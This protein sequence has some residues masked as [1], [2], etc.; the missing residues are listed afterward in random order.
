MFG[1][2]GGLGDLAGN[3]Y[4]TSSG[5]LGYNG[6]SVS[7]NY[8]TALPDPS[9]LQDP[10]ATIIFKSLLKKDSITKEKSLNE[11]LSYLDDQSTPVDDIFTVSWIQLYPKLAMDNSRNARV[12]A[13]QVQ[14]KL[15]SRLGGKAFSRYLKSSIPVWLSGVFDSDNVVSR[16]SYKSLVESFQDK[17]KVDV[18]LWVLFYEP[19]VNYIRTALTMETNESLSDPRYTKEDDSIAKYDRVVNGALTMLAKLIGL[20]N[21]G[22]LSENEKTIG[23]IDW[24]TLEQ[25]VS[26]DSVWDGHLE[27]C[28]ATKTLNL[29][30]FK[31]LLILIKAIFGGNVEGGS[32][33]L[34]HVEPKSL[35]KLISK[36]FLKHVK[37]KSSTTS[38]SV[39]ASIILQFWDTLVIL[40]R[41]SSQ[42]NSKVKKNF[43]DFSDKARSRLLGYLKLG[44][45]QSNPAYYSIIGQFFLELSKATKTE[46][47]DFKSNK[48]AK[49]ILVDILASDFSTLRGNDWKSKCL[50]CL[51]KVHACFK[52]VGNSLE[53]SQIISYQVLDSINGNKEVLTL[54]GNSFPDLEQVWAPF[55]EALVAYSLQDREENQ[56]F[57][58]GQYTFK[59][60]DMNVLATMYMKL[61]TTSKDQD[62]LQSLVGDIFE[63]ILDPELLRPSLAFYIIA[64][65]FKSYHNPD[66]NA[67]ATTQQYNLLDFMDNLPAY[68]EEDFVGPP[69]E[70]MSVI[71]H[72]FGGSDDKETTERLGE[73]VNDVFIKL[74]MVSPSKVPSFLVTLSEVKF[75]LSEHPEMFAYVVELS[76]RTEQLSADEAKVVFS[77]TQDDAIFQNLLENSTKSD[78]DGLVFIGSLLNDNKGQQLESTDLDSLLAICW[79]NI[80]SSK[81]ARSFVESGF[82][83]DEVLQKSLFEHIGNPT[84][85][86]FVELQKYFDIS[87]PEYFPTQQLTD[88]VEL[89]IESD[90]LQTPASQLSIANTVEQ[91]IVLGTT[92]S[93]AFNL[94]KSLVSVGTFL[95]GLK[96]VA[97]NEPLLFATG[98]LSE[99][100]ADVIFLGKSEDNHIVSLQEKLHNIFI[101]SVTAGLSLAD[102]VSV[103]DGGESKHTIS[104]II[105]S[106]STYA[107]RLLKLIVSSILDGVSL[108]NFDSQFTINLSK[109]ATK[110][111]LQFGSILLACS[112]FLATSSKF[113][114]IR[115]FVAAEILGVRGESKILSDGLKWLTLSINFLFN[116]DNYEFIPPHRLMMVLNTISSWLESDIAYDEEF[117][118]MRCQISRFLVGLMEYDDTPS[119]VFELAIQL[120]HDN[121]GTIQVEPAHLELKYFTL[122][123][124]IALK[125]H[126]DEATWKEEQNTFYEEA[127]DI[128]VN[129]DVQ[130]QDELFNNQ[131]VSL[132]HTLLV[133]FFQKANISKSILQDKNLELYGLLECESIDLQRISVLLLHGLILESQQDF[134]VDYQLRKS[135]IKDDNSDEEEQSIIA[136]LP[137]VLLSL[138]KSKFDDFIEFEKATKVA[139]F[140]WSWSLI[141][142]HFVDITYSLRHE[143]TVQ[144]KKYNSIDEL[145]DFI[146][147]QVDVTDMALLKDLEETSIQTFQPVT[148]SLIHEFKFS[149]LHL[150]YLSLEHFGSSVS[151]WYN[152]I[153]DRQLKL[154]IEKFTTK[155]V[156]P[157]IVTKI[158][159]DV[160]SSS[161]KNAS[162]EIMTL[163]VNKVTNEIRSIYLIDDQNMEMVV[164]IPAT[165]PLAKVSVEGPLRLGVKENQWKAWLLASQRVISL[166]NGSII[167]AIELF[168]KNVNLHF[169]GFEDCAICYSILH[170]DHSLPTKNCPTCNN[171]FHAA[172]L[173]KWFKSSGGST[174]PLCRSTFNFTRR[175]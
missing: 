77:Y 87:L 49:E 61:I 138:I 18:K 133:R 74:T 113:D 164:K 146:F 70:L 3:A 168:N 12:L 102:V 54:L 38:K 34:S 141:F 6:F 29:S 106:P 139:S 2:S 163:K 120:C 21:D 23:E 83:A 97:E 136:E 101:E 36:K 25:L 82:A 171:K 94:E 79:R 126:L 98:L 75:N 154:K 96:Q 143:Y 66:K 128:M 78:K 44:S 148:D 142:D 132:C 1:T 14:A 150:Y 156:S 144:L 167:E 63:G 160:A 15:L 95:L 152:G 88:L 110:N 140:I 99:Y 30:L 59:T 161:A 123:L 165:Y 33:F 118:V 130:G 26:A 47:I 115:N 8:F 42:P 158:L 172:C 45:C 5:D 151:T 46:V 170:Q 135:T 41:Y 149:L 159:D 31:T 129:K 127:L 16:E 84:T 175:S 121:F 108:S 137:S 112:Q 147:Q 65:Y 89:T 40:T 125:R 43:W 27:R 51:I 169:S 80:G 50:A 17:E 90:T 81:S 157:L 93:T 73:S 71:L 7:L 56:S 37:L 52:E 153:R 24:S 114:R 103:I 162:D 19:I 155:Y 11:L 4:G 117:I 131:S 57:S 166:T 174:C 122:K 53:I 10:N 86:N 134:V 9:H 92:H 173:Y 119:K 145:L 116:E 68:I 69:I 100:F 28:L 32:L 58:V 67:A 13:H 20:V 85:T 62:Q 60:K 104:L 91:N 72:V 39:L 109:L 35:Y 55:K 48:D 124:A 76:K 64:E 111:P 105:N 22:T 107:A